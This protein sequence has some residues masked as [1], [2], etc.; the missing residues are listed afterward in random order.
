MY[1]QYPDKS[2]T[3]SK[4]NPVGF[5]HIGAVYTPRVLFYVDAMTK[6]TIN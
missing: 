4:R 5:M 2:N 1:I 3:V 6:C